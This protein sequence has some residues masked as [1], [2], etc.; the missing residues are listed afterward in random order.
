VSLLAALMGDLNTHND[1]ADFHPQFL[2]T[3][4]V[5]V[6][7]EDFVSIKRSI[8]SL[9]IMFVIFDSWMI[10]MLGDGSLNDSIFDSAA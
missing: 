7:S 5:D 4:I 2:G 10:L 3:R 6:I 1:F 9:L 8:L